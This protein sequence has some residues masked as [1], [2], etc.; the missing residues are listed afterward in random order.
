MKILV[1]G[2]AG[3]IGSA[4]VRQLAEEDVEV[5]AVDC[6]LEALYPALPKLRNWEQFSQYPNVQ[7]YEF[8]L[9]NELPNQFLK[10][11]DSVINEAGMPGLMK[12]WSEFQTYSSCNIEITERLCRAA[13]DADVQQF[14]QI[15]T[16]SVYGENAV[17]DET[18]PTRPVSPYGV[19]KLAAEELVK[20]YNRSKDLPYNIL[21]YFSVYG[22]GQRPDMAYYKL[23]NSALTGE[24]ITIFGDGHQ[25]RTNTFVEDCAKATINAATRAGDGEI[26]NISGLVSHSLLE[27]IS[28][29]EIATGK[30]INKK[31][32]NTRPGDQ[33]HTAGDSTKAQRAL[34]F[35]QSVSLLE[36]LTQQAKWQREFQTNV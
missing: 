29:I 9:R 15:S 12:S 35:S 21:R 25:T 23:I 28:I 14:V 8:D 16:S 11:V 27:A 34:H 5:V 33:R 20:T 10:G 17:G 24:Q 7:R 26:Y 2:A 36:G 3:F 1:T 30:A 13:V 18:T 6:F 4:V 32:E 22:P 31:F 19:T